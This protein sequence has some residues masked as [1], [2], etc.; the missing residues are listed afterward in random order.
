MTR[1]DIEIN[2]RRQRLV[3]CAGDGALQPYEWYIRREDPAARARRIARKTVDPATAA[4]LR[5]LW[6][7][8]PRTARR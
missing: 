7:E 5:R 2:E 6:A 8:S 4:A 3:E 1:V